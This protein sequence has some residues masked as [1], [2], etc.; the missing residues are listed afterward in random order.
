M[1]KFYAFILSIIFL[2]IP[3]LIISQSSRDTHYSVI[4]VYT[5]PDI[6]DGEVIQVTGYYTNSSDHFLIH[7]YGD[8]IK[9]RPFA[10]HTVLTL[11]GIDPPDEALEGGYILVT[12]T[13]SFVDV[14][15]PYHPADNRMAY[16]DATEITVI[17]PS[18]AFSGDGQSG[19]KIKKAAGSGDN[20]EITNGGCDPCKFAF[21][22][23]GGADSTNNHSKYWENLVALYKFKVDSLGY[24]DS[25]VFVHYFKGDR[26][27]GRIPSGRVLKADSAKI[28]S[29]F[30]VIANRV[31]ACNDAGTPATFQ[32]MI[33]NHGQ[34][35][36]GI[37]LLGNDVITPEHLKD[38]QQKIIDSCCRTV[39]D[40]FIQ[41]YGGI[42]VDA[43]ST[44]DT[45]NKATVYA[46]SNAN[47]ACGYSP[48]NAVHPY[49]QAKINALDTG[50]SYPDAVVKAKLAYDDYLESYLQRC[51]NALVWW[52]NHPEE[53]DQAEAIAAWTA[54]SIA[55]AAAICKSRNVT[56]VPFTT[57][58]Q[59]QKFVVPPGGQLVIDFSG[60]SGSCGNV[61]V[62]RVDPV[63]GA[64]IKVTVWNWNH[65]GSTGYIPGN[66]QRAIT[67][68]FTS[69]TT[70]WVHNDNAISRLKVQ[71]LGSPVRPDSPA[72][73]F[74]Y[75]G[76]SFGGTNNS[77]S[78]FAPIPVPNYFIPSIEMLGMSLQ[79]LPAILGPGYVQNLGF[80]FNIDPT[81]G[82]WSDMEM[83]LNVS[84]V[85]NPGILMIQSPSGSIPMA[86]L[87]IEGP[88]AYFVQLGD[89]TLNGPEGFCSMITTEGLWIELDS[90]GW[91]SRLN[92]LPPQST[93]WTG[94]VSSNWL[95]PANWTD[96]VPGIFDHVQIM[97]GTFQPVVFTDVIIKSLTISEET[98]IIL[99][100][101]G[102]LL[103]TGN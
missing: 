44:L 32:K 76:F 100:P 18:P 85:I 2:L 83:V 98:N 74:S 90:W 75:P 17:M 84:Q 89:F 49:L 33:S 101:G 12:G 82:F 48:P 67:G 15:D 28:D 91:R 55:V 10:P 8:Y 31:A 92:T 59:W 14:T 4:D 52:R 42:V 46:N 99:A 36:G 68:D 86:S 51:H 65:P 35:D 27:D 23:S 45:K 95:D 57:Y 38:Q 69:S 24:C 53:P 41:C 5:D 79:S 103:V 11:S 64:L 77:S 19:Q 13:V 81:N 58:C 9:D 66:E 43:V 54:D 16:L 80:S 20:R 88:G 60:S 22:L 97:P 7:F 61:T 47:D 78:E 21:L 93:I 56:I 50:S 40:E 73:V 63:T 29:V 72:N 30:Q 102:Y 70:F 26:R 6:V 39:Y 71:A 94:L 3:Q 25:N 62:Y 37:C 34:S 96:G 1:K 87:N